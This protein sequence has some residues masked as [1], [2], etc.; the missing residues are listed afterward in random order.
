MKMYMLF[1]LMGL[2]IAFSYVRKGGGT[3]AAD[4]AAQARIGTVRKN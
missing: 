1:M 2:F 4:P 3:G